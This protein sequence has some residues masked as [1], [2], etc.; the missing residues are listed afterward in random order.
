VW[1]WI[2]DGAF[3]VKWTGSDLDAAASPVLVESVELVHRG[4]KRG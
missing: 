2:F 3:P 4:F 1:R